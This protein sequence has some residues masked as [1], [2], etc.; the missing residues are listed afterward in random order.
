MRNFLKLMASGVLVLALLVSCTQESSSDTKTESTLN[1]NKANSSEVDRQPEV[2]SENEGSTKSSTYE[3]QKREKDE[4]AEGFKQNQ[5]FTLACEVEY[6]EGVTG[7]EKSENPTALGSSSFQLS[8]VPSKL[9]GYIFNYVQREGEAN[10]ELEQIAKKLMDVRVFESNIQ[11]DNLSVDRH[12]LQIEFFNGGPM[13]TVVS[14]KMTIGL[15]KIE[16][17][18]IEIPILE[19]KF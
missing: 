1:G 4:E 17:H 5:P 8:I 7:L 19:R 16:S 18:F 14:G 13:A 15:C 11:M 10:S 2:N 3:T 6:F 12:T 9:K